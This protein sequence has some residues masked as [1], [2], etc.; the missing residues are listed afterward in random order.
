MKKVGYFFCLMLFCGV[1]LTLV[2]CHKCEFGA[3]QVVTAATC[4]EQGEQIRYC[5]GDETH[6]EK[7][8]IPALGHKFSAWHEMN[9]PTFELTGEEKRIC[10]RCSH[11]E[12]REVP[13]L[14]FTTSFQQLKERALAGESKIFIANDIEIENSVFITNKTEL[15]PLA[16]CVLKRS[17]NFLGDMFVIGENELGENVLLQGNSP[18]LIL[19]SSSE[20]ILTIDGNSQHMQ[21]GVNGSA[22]LVLYSG[23]LDMYKNVVVTNCE[24]VGNKKLV[25]K[26]Y[27][28][29]YPNKVGG[30]GVVVVNGTFNMYGGEFANCQVNC[31]EDDESAI[32]CFGGAVYNFS[33]VNIGGGIFRNCSA[34]RGGAI[35][36]YRTCLVN[37]AT[38][39]GNHA[40]IY[41]GAIYLP[42]SQYAN[43]ILGDEGEAENVLFKNNSS[44]KSGGAIFGQMKTSIDVYGNTAFRKNK[45]LNSNG[46]AIST[47]GALTIRFANFDSNSAAS[48]GG[49]IY[50]YYSNPE[51]TERMVTIYNAVFNNNS[52]SR[53]GAIVFSSSGADF[54]KGSKGFIGAATFSNNYAFTTATSDPELPDG[55]DATAGSFYGYGGAIYVSRKSELE[56]DGA[57]FVSNSADSK[58]GAI[59][60][61][62]LSNT[63]IANAT[64]MQNISAGNGGAMYIYTEKDGN[65]TN[66]TSVEIINSTF[67]ENV[68]NSTN[69]GGG[70]LYFTN[71]NGIL[72]EV[73]LKANQSKYNGGAIAAYSA[74][75][76]TISKLQA[77]ENI[78]QNNGGAIYFNDSF[79]NI[80]ESN[81]SKNTANSTE[82]GG[83]AIYFTGSVANLNDI[84]LTENTTS[85]N[86]G[87][88]ALY[89]SSNLTAS[90]LNAEQNTS[91]GNGGVIY[92]S[93]SEAV[94][95]DSSFKNNT[96]TGVG[97]VF[98]VYSNTELTINGLVVSGNKANGTGGGVMYATGAAQVSID[99]I[100]ATGNSA[101]KGGFL[102]ITTTGTKVSLLGGS[103]TENHASSDEN[104]NTVWS[105]TKK[106]TVAVDMANFGYIADDFKGN[107]TLEEI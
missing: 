104:G 52:A 53:G 54:E 62:A 73:S 106:C 80:G 23:K 6:F 16:D 1:L 40:S 8:V 48:K 91:T 41:A 30:A 38:F 43:L 87:A 24:K 83:G 26:D 92:F 103:A 18:Q 5:K 102:Y 46:G 31:V 37:E 99:G 71:S 11:E 14:E 2:G 7:K 82:Y 76:L 56:I 29:R 4:T 55:D 42:E 84:I 20:H 45:T 74:S 35:Y 39:D 49:A 12:T 51:L 89:S 10:E 25:E 34:S 63:K 19:N 81:F 22:F 60:L 70:A 59:Y 97:G 28:L 79:V 67:E 17:E 13:K 86:G 107:L 101:S 58:G 66:R 93:K 3:W 72:T 77:G 69:Y 47:S 65:S 100:E 85:G 21:G 32:S 75:E 88:I 9:A 94:I 64:F 50:A 78:A 90:N 15:I 105:N 95:S 98:G 44:G 61:T 68:S 96:A 57:K 36:N 33:T 27:N